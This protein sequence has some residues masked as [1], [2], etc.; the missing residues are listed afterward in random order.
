METGKTERRWP[1]KDFLAQVSEGRI[2]MEVFVMPTD[3]DSA[4]CLKGSSAAAL[5]VVRS[6]SGTETELGIYW[7]LRTISSKHTYNLRVIPYTLRTSLTLIQIG[8]ANAVRGCSR[9]TKA[10]S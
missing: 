6:R 5:A 9:R 7:H 1:D 4:S 8:K 3:L 2:S 10:M